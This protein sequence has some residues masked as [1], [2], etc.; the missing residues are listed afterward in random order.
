MADIG[1]NT[2]QAL[3]ALDA[4]GQR[5]ATKHGIMLQQPAFSHYY[6][7]LGEISTYPP[8]YKENAGIF[9]HTNPWIMIAET[10]LDRGDKAL[11]Y[12]LRINPSARETISEL[13][14]TEPYVYSQM[15]AGR[16]APTHGEAKNSWLSGTAA[17]NYVAISQWI[18]GVRPHYDGLQISPVVP[19]D[20]QTFK[21]QRKFRQTTYNIRV[22]RTGPGNQVSILVNGKDI[23][24]NIISPQPGQALD[25]EVMLS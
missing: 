10:R 9:C 13:H 17:W 23:Q 15:I 18:L 20:W 1:L 19:P 7:N 11:D 21:M 6:L 3:Q 2:G 25:V 8:G 12:Y 16:D 22:T 14:K 5:L 4:V 24:G